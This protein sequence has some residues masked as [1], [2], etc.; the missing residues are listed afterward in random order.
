MPAPIADDWRRLALRLVIA[1]TAARLVLLAFDRTDLYVDE[2]QYWLWGQHFAFGYYSKP[3]LIAWVIGL[4]TWI[5]GDN[6]Y[7]VRAPFA[8]FH[9]ATAL[10]L[11]ALAD[12][13]YGPRVAMLTALTYVTLPMAAVGSLLAST[14]TIMAPF[15]A[16]ALYY[17]HR[18]AQE[19]RT[20]L[21]VLGG[22][23]LGLAFLAKYASI[24]FLLGAGLAVVIHPSLRIG[25]R[26]ALW[27]LLAFAAVATPNIVWNAL[28][29]FATVSH[30]VDNVSWIRQPSPLGAI[31]PLSL[32]QFLG[33]QFAVAGPLVFA[34]TLAA[35][36]RP[37]TARLA[38]FA[39]PPLVIVSVQA[40]LEQA[41]ANWAASAY[42]AGT[43]AAVALLSHRPRLMG[44]SLAIN[45]AL[46]LIVPLLTIFPTF[47]LGD[48]PILVRYLGQAEMSR[49]IIDL[50]IDNDGLPI[51]ASRRD[52]LAD[53]F[54][55]G[56]ESNLAFYA[57]PPKGRALNHYEQVYPLPADITGK[58]L[59]IAGRPPACPEAETPAERLPLDAGQGTYSRME[60]KAFIIDAACIHG[61]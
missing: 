61:N 38:V 48:R 23:C 9:G 55:T 57:V 10:I 17:W 21:A 59:Y 8:L 45:G 44:A 60:L 56:A 51:V 12:R 35:I 11:A 46:S 41:Y 18:L 50:A 4:S 19:R 1:V 20:H 40:L 27:L 30:T 32:V 16:G 3:P 49:Q 58:V 31:S 28:N 47:S 52:V 26:N 22:L 53:L 6:A 42:F 29:G 5:G 34:A 39:L 13:I 25:W 33:A 36:F 15:F 7:F 43:V 2:S 37:Q 24:Y 54:F 14:D